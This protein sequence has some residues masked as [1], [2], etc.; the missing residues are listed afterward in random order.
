M[1]EQDLMTIFEGQ[2]DQWTVDVRIVQ[3][4]VEEETLI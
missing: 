2:R 4:I 3:L 1:Y